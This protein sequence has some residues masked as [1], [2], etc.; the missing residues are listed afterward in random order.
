MTD[1]HQGLLKDGRQLEWSCASTCHKSGNRTW[2]IGTSS[3]ALTKSQL[4]WLYC[5]CVFYQEKGLSEKVKNKMKQVWCN[6][7]LHSVY[8]SENSVNISEL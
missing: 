4:H 2:D 6:L 3:W 7:L 5:H 1:E 8:I